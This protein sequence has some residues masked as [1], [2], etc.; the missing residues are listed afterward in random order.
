M[1]G[2]VKPKKLTQPKLVSRVRIVHQQKIMPSEDGELL[3]FN[4]TEETYLDVEVEVDA[5]V[6][7]E[8]CGVTVKNLDAHRRKVHG[9]H[10]ETLPTSDVQAKAPTN[11]LFTLVKCPVCG[12][13]VGDLAKHMK[14]AKHIDETKRS[15]RQVLQAEGG[16]MICPF[17][18]SRWPNRADVSLHI[19]RAHGKQA[20]AELRFALP[21]RPIV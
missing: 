18:S 12:S 4:R 14:K 15:T 7:C 2:N 16:E 13:M 11:P 1:A 8:D 21:R 10:A 5:A 3:Q 19:E 9:G 17:C 6:V 20:R